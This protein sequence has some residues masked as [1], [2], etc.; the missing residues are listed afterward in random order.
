MHLPFCNSSLPALERAVDLVSRL[1]VS[2]KIAQL[3]D[4]APPIPHLHID[5]YN[6]WTSSLHGILAD[7]TKDGRCPTSKFV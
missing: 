6:Y 4:S 1:N 3:M 7:C 5:G 2:E